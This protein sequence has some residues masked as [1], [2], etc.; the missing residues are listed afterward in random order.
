MLTHTKDRTGRRIGASVG[1]VLAGFVTT[2]ALSSAIDA[3]LHAAGVYP[4]LG[5]RMSD[6]LFGLAL[7]YRGLAAIA[8]GW[9]TARL[10]PSRPMRHALILAGV[11]SLAG[12]A[13]V[14]VAITQPEIGPLWYPV[15]LVV[16]ALP[17][18][19]LGARWRA[20]LPAG[21]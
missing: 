13:G 9:V 10:A 15:L 7:V 11:G 16:T 20:R 19:W 12:L 1:A 18:I 5:V 21:A 3:V 6:G 8:G 17:C 2:F 4:R 14:A